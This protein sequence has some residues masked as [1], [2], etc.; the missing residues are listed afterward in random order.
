MW[1]K[2]RLIPS[3][4]VFQFLSIFFD[5]SSTALKISLFL[6]SLVRR[7]NLVA[8]NSLFRIDKLLSEMAISF[9]DL[10]S[11]TRKSSFSCQLNWLNAQFSVFRQSLEY[12][13]CSSLPWI[14]CVI[15]S[16][17]GLLQKFLHS[18]TLSQYHSCVSV[19][20]C[21]KHNTRRRSLSMLMLSYSDT[22]TT[23][24]GIWNGAGVTK[25]WFLLLQLP[26]LRL[27][28]LLIFISRVVGEF[29]PHPFTHQDQISCV[30]NSCLTLISELFPYHLHENSDCLKTALDRDKK[31]LQGSGVQS[32]F[33]GTHTILYTHWG[34]ECQSE[35]APAL[36]ENAFWIRVLDWQIDR[37]TAE[38]V[39]EW[40]R[41]TETKRWIDYGCD[42][43]SSCTV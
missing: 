22:L 38:M 42:S 28:F 31:L 24:M 36:G 17:Y 11:E 29:A 21:P 19:W 7:L 43:S 35:R 4:T 34:C 25:T 30:S 8:I 20:P 6:S 27:F 23:S 16:A 3:W 33:R 9:S 5:F 13:D 1:F 18:L 14:H 26:C 32:G 39:K 37:D 12:F 10:N 41:E 2:E 15:W 40:I